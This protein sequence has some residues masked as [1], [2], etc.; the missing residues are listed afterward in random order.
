M[1]LLLDTFIE[2]ARGVSIKQAAERLHL[3]FRQSG[4]EHPQTCPAC[5]GKDRFSFN[6]SK[7]KWHCRGDGVGGQ[8]A[9]GMAA[10][11]LG[12]D[13]KRRKDFLDACAAVTGEAIPAGEEQASDVER[14][15]REARLA[16][17]RRRN[18]EDDA[19]HEAQQQDFRERERRKARGIVEAATPLAILAR[20][21]AHSYIHKRGGQVPGSLWLRFSNAQPYWHGQGGG[22]DGPLFEGPAMVAPF[23]DASLS[24]IGCHITWIDLYNPPKYRPLVTDVATGAALPSKKMRGSKKGGLIPLAGRPSAERWVGG[25]GIENGLAFGA[26][27][28]FREDTF[29]FAAGDL[30]NLA[31][32]AELS[33][34]FAH[35]TL[36]RPDKAGRERPVMV[37]GPV[38]K[39]CQAPDDAMFVLPHVTELVFLADADSER[40]MTAAAMARARAR[41][42][43]DGR[44]ILVLWPKR[45]RDFSE[46]ALE[47]EQD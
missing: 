45:G 31:G 19:R 20:S 14:A 40:V 28:C 29:Y 22:N 27:E 8:D 24:I 39:A 7:N 32:P 2:D 35:P 47:F 17:Q 11:V 18:A 23:I 30:G 26:W 46:L 4:V 9:I 10:H 41:C 25:E 3:K 6:T 33:S 42:H 5:G 12:L 21:P 13:L 16:E 36:T 1:T 15:E 37:A 34:R 38:P 43:A 44:R